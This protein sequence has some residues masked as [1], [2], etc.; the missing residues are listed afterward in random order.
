MAFLNYLRSVRQAKQLRHL[1]HILAHPGVIAPRGLL[2]IVLEQHGD[3]IEV[4]C[5]AFGI[6][7]ASV[8]S[9]VPI[10]FLWH[11]RRDD[12]WEPI[13]LYNGTKQAVLLFSDRAADLATIPAARREALSRWIREWRDGCGRPRPPPHVWTPDRDSAGL[14]RLS[15]FVHTDLTQS[16]VRDRSNR[17]AGVLM[18]VTGGTDVVFFPCLDDGTL[19]VKKSRVYEATMIPPV[20]LATYLQAYKE[21]AASYSALTPTQLLIRITDSGSAP[22]IVGLELAVGTM[23]PVAPEP[24]V[25]DTAPLPAQQVDA[26]PWERDALVL[27]PAD[28]PPTQL[29]A[30]EESTAS[31]EEQLAEAYQHVRLS[32]SHLLPRQPA[33][34]ANI[35][36]IISR[37]LAL[38]ER[39]KRM[40]IALEP[41]IRTMIATEESTERRTLPLL[42]V[43]CLSLGDESGCAAAGACRWSGG[44]CLIHTPVRPGGGG[45][46]SVVRIMTARLSD[47]LLR[48][49]ARRRELF[50][51][52]VSEIR[53]PRGA[54][55]IGDELFIATRQNE[56]ADVVID[57]LGITGDI[58]MTF[59]EEM[60]RFEGADEVVPAAPPLPALTPLVPAL[61]PTTAAATFPT[62]WR[63]AG[64]TVASPAPGLENA[65]LL[66]FA[67]A[68]GISIVDWNSQVKRV[69]KTM[70]LVGAPERPIQ[71]STQDKYVLA[72]SLLSN[73]IT[74][75]ADGSVLQ[76]ITPSSKFAK[77]ASNK[78]IVLWGPQQL[79]LFRKS[80]KRKYVFIR[81]ELPKEIQES[82]AESAGPIPEADA[83]GYVEATVPVLA[84]EDEGGVSE[85]KSDI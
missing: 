82:L 69:R 8:Y 32:F 48:Y 28:A 71:W 5:P 75:D 81:E 83:Q 12:T 68:S 78:F 61:V 58:P 30:M 24:Y 85:T 79:T 80:P 33:L 76:W 34:A 10:A 42:R 41:I 16:L 15:H 25:A 17:L 52:E 56:A 37:Q 29:T 51:G 65:T 39:R 63:E 2:L 23:V 74:T 26:F 45:A 57:R 20:P 50:D 6:P 35:R 70:G 7:P 77:K 1:E 73:I 44:R 60:L 53:T 9:E 19:A 40:D 31:V 21:I 72:S 46:A 22:Q 64:F 27:R 67:E 13:V 49:A 11:D 84:V 43:D 59:P 14:P 18:K 38:Y 66:A 36:R 3:H 4:I 62:A 55:R 54:V 47:E